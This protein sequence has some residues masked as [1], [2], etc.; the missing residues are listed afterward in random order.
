MY[1]LEFFLKIK[2]FTGSVFH[3]FL[4]FQFKEYSNSISKKTNYISFFAL[5][6]QPL[7]QKARL[8]L[9]VHELMTLSPI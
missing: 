7:G 6:D 3:G 2:L 4:L 5:F 9:V 8:S 1:V